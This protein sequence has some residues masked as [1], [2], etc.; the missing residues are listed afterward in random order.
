MPR[1][2]GLLVEESGQPG[3]VKLCKLTEVSPFVGHDPRVDV[4][5]YSLGVR[6][7]RYPLSTCLIDCLQICLIKALMVAPLVQLWIRE[8]QKMVDV[9]PVELYFPS[10]DGCP[11]VNAS[12]LALLLS[13]VPHFYLCS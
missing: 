3:V 1:V 4:L 5:E 2:D 6:H 8:P 13:N 7:A 9:L 10:S 11:E 12:D